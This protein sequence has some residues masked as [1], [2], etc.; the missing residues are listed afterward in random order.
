MLDLKIPE[1]RYRTEIEGLRTIATL[2]IAIY[3]IWLGKVSG[4]VDVFFVLSGFLI[5]M[6]LISK[7]EKTGKIYFRDY[8]LGLAKRLFPLA[9]TVII[10]ITGL[11]I[12]LLPRVQ[13]DQTISHMF[14]STLFF[15]NWRLS[16]DAVDYL[17]QDNVASP[18]QHFWSMSVQG[19]FYILWPCLIFAAYILARKVLKTPVRKTL[20]AVLL[21]VFILSLSY[22]IYIT[23]LNQP[24]AYFDLLARIWEFSLGGIFAILLP[25]LSLNKWLSTFIGWVGLLIVCFTGV[26]IPV[27]DLFPGYIALLP[28]GGALLLL[29]SAESSTRFGVDKILG[30][31]PFLFLGRYTYG[32]Y[33]WHWPLLIFYKVYMDTS[34]VSIEHGLLII[35][36]TFILSYV[37]TK[38]IETPIRK[39]D[40]RQSKSKLVSVLCVML[41][42]VLLMNYSFNYYVEQEKAQKPLEYSTQ[43][44]PGALALQQNIQVTEGVELIPSMVNVKTDLPS[45]YDDKQCFSN[46]GAV[47][48]KCSFGVTDDPDYI[49]ALVGGS[50]SGHWFPALEILAEELNF[51]VDVYIR[52]GCR[53]TNDDSGGQVTPE[54]LSWN[55]KLMDV[56]IKDPPDMVFTTATLNR[57]DTVPIGYI[58]QWSRLEGIT[59]IFAVRDNPRMAEDVPTCL[60]RESDPSECSIPKDQGISEIVPWENTEGIPSNVTFADLSDNFCDD[61]RCYSVIGNIIVYRDKHH[62]TAEYAKTLAPALREPLEDALKSL[63]KK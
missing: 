28:I 33:L 13:W 63:D 39:I 49:I 43:D 1:K 47:I 45:F 32:F 16:L 34:T 38:F 6:S 61:S 60:E 59:Q 8:L 5:T 58:G 26:I 44:Y 54:C 19:Q 30:A 12:L 50:H 29:L 22:S 40:V 36:A 41:F 52:D 53:F 11:S 3:H 56:L 27:S 31:K 7:I 23:N 25:Y 9:L 10:F 48:T 51:Q 21:I 24:W 2:L 14:A 18:F 37:S 57:M 35:L 62:I 4:G 15:E 17:A 20:L 42:P 55:E 46:R